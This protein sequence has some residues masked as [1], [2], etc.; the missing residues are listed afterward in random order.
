MMK[1]TIFQSNNK[2]TFN[3]EHTNIG[4]LLTSNLLC[5]LL[6]LKLTGFLISLQGISLLKNKSI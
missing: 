1:G 2:Y 5:A 6:Q 4:R 3:F